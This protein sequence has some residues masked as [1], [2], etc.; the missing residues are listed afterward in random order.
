MIP[1]S[2]FFIFVTPH[3]TKT[4]FSIFAKFLICLFLNFENFTTKKRAFFNGK[5]E[6]Y[7][8]ALLIFFRISGTTIIP[9]FA[10]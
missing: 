8:M 4:V 5:K 3:Y 10:R 6:P 9:I 1:P 7:L 2:F